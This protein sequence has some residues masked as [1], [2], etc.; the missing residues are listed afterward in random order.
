MEHSTRDSH[1]LKLIEYSKSLIP[2]L[3]GRVPSCEALRHVPN[4][5]IEDVIRGGLIRST[6]PK[7][8]GGGEINYHTAM[9]ICAAI[10]YGCGSTGIVV[11][12]MMGCTLTAALWPEEAQNVIWKDS[13]DTIITGTL[14]FPKG[15]ARRVKG[16]YVLSGQWPFG[17]GILASSWNMFGAVVQ[18]DSEHRETELRMFLVPKADWS[19]IDTWAAS[20]LRGSGSHDVLVENKFV[21]NFMT[22]SAYDQKGNCAPGC[23]VNSGPVYRLPIFAMFISWLGSVVLGIAESAVDQFLIDTKS[24]ITVYTN[25]KLT[26]LSP[27]Q[28]KAAEAKMSVDIARK[29]YLQNCEEAMNLAL[30]NCQPTQQERV[31]WR[32]EGAFAARMCDSAVDILHTASGGSGLYDTNL[33]SRAFR[34]IH[35]A[36]AQITQNFDVNATT[37][38]RYL[39]GIETDNDLL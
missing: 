39:L 7:R 2:T 13:V 10:S 37:Y 1:E 29:I 15:E 18:P 17:S 30:S 34:D 12:N 22:I 8:L 38:G 24:R 4:E 14:I 19:V 6:A 9:Q 31:K 21:P 27:I 36:Q 20:S 11:A 33:I 35:G 28:I 32:G 5:T 23:K 3:R 26:S 16:G 25:K